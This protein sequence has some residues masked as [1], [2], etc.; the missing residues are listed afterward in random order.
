MDFEGL[1]PPDRHGVYIENAGEHDANGIPRARERQGDYWSWISGFLGLRPPVSAIL[2]SNDGARPFFGA[3]GGP[4]HTGL[5][6]ND[7]RWEAMR[8][9]ER[10]IAEANN[11]VPFKPTLGEVL[12]E[13]VEAVRRVTKTDRAKAWLAE[14]LRQGPV[15]QQ[16]IE[17]EGRDQGFTLKLLKV[18]KKR[19][20]V[21]SVR[22]GA[23]NWRWQLPMASKP[24]GGNE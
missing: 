4:V 1:Q 5:M 10:R 21:V 7:M 16:V 24:K 19:L 9:R 22:K 2:D 23:N 3:L 18:V 20:R 13:V 11:S 6:D 8:R 14:R 15:A 17:A 12:G